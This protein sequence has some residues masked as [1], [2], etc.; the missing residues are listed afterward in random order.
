MDVFSV[1][2]VSRRKIRGKSVCRSEEDLFIPLGVCL[3]ARVPTKAI[4][5]LVRV[6]VYNMINNKTCFSHTLCS[7]TYVDIM[8]LSGYK[9]SRNL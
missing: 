5:T 6:T 2:C 4:Y 9:T 8:I 7:H 1:V 3:F